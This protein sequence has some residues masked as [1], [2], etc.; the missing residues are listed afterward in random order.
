MNNSERIYN[1]YS[2]VSPG[3]VQ[4]NYR[5]E[6]PHPTYFKSGSGSRIRDVDGREF[7]DYLI[8]YG[9]IILG[10]GDPRVKRAVIEALE[11]GLTSG[12][13]T[14]LDFKLVETLRNMIP[15]AEMARVCNSG[16]EA[17]M[18]ALMI[19]RGY[20]GKDKVVKAEGGYHGWYDPVLVSYHP[21]FKQAG[22]EKNP[23]PI[24]ASLGLD[25]AALGSAL[26]VPYNDAASARRIIKSHRDEIAAVM[27]EPICFN[28]GALMPKKGFLEELREIT[29]ELD[30]PLIFDEVITGFRIAPGGAQEYFGIEPDLSIFGKAMGNG[31]PISA[32][33]GR[34]DLIN[35]S[36]PGGKVAYAGTYNGNQIVAAASHSTLSI[37]KDGSVQKYLA[38]STEYLR[39]SIESLTEDR[40]YGVHFQGVGGK[41]QIFFADQIISNYRETIAVNGKTWAL[42]RKAMLDKGVLFHQ[43]E[44][45]HHGITRAHSRQDLVDFLEKFGSFLDW[46]DQQGQVAAPVPRSKR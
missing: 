37:L 42:F 3:G 8:G 45:F 23:L 12:V 34:A 13:E 21:D 24:P 27:I 39:E 22:P 14:E 26:I 33:T 15:S 4:S 2:K 18:H 46:L 35:L 17:V 25:R 31:Y 20:T 7:C 41:F 43:H 6:P 16:T 1:E 38:E 44:L 11:L 9:S 36:K 29:R 19:A 40:K 28:T 5:F 32:I 30:I 10:H